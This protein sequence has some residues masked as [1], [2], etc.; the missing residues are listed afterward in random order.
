MK[1]PTY[2]DA[3]QSAVTRLRTRTIPECCD[4]STESRTSETACAAQGDPSSPSVSSSE[5]TVSG[6]RPTRP[7]SETTT[8]S[9][10]S[11]ESTV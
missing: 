11:S 9:A 1:E 10:G 5:W 7:S 6:E 2:A 4:V 8:M 3:A